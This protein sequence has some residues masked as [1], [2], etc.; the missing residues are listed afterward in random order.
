[1]LIDT[2]MVIKML[3]KDFRT[4]TLVDVSGM[5]YVKMTDII[6]GTLPQFSRWY[7]I[8]HLL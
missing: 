7:E 6:T 2:D 3:F 1:M 5:M 8:T 4:H